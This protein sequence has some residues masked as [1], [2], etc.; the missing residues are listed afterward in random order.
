MAKSISVFISSKMQ[1]LRAERQALESLLPTLGDDTVTLRPW[2]FESDATAS[3]SS[4]R[5][6]YLQALDES[7][8]YIGLFWNEYGEWTIDEFYRAGELGITRHI[9]VKDVHPERRDPRLIEFLEKQSDVRFGITPRW[10]HDVDELRT[11]VARSVEQWLMERQVAHHSATSVIVAHSEDDIPEVPRRLIGR[12]PLIEQVDELLDDNERVLLRGFGGM[13]KTAL[14]ASIAAERAEAGKT[15]VIWIKA[16]MADTSALFEAT[17]RAFDAQQQLTNTTG[18]ERIQ[19]IRSILAEHKR[20]LVVLDDAWNGTALAEYVKAI[21]RR[22]PLLVTS[23]QRFPLDVIIE[24]GELAPEEALK[25]LRY[26]A[27]RDVENDADALLLCEMLGYHA[28]ALEIA[29]KT[30]KVYDMAPG[31]LLARIERAPHDLQ[32]PYGF[33]ELGRGGIKSLLDA[34]IDA[35]SKD[36][37]DLFMTMGGL[38]EPTA[39]PE[40]LAFTTGFS[41]PIIETRLSE[42]AERGLANERS[43]QQVRYY[44]MHDLAYSYARTM[45]VNRGLSETPVIEAARTFTLQYHD[46]LPH[47]DIEQS[48]ILEAVEAAQHAGMNETMIDMMS[49]LAV[50]G[51]YFA[52]RGHSSRSLQLMQATINVAIEQNRLEDAHYLLSRLGNTYNDF[53]G[54]QERALAVYRQA[55]GLARDLGM[56]AREAILLAV[57]AKVRFLQQAEDADDYYDQAEQCARNLDDAGAL[58]FVL[59]HRGFHEMQK[60]PP[61]YE[62]GR[63]LSDEAARLAQQLDRTDIHFFSLINRGGCELMLEQPER[64]LES[65]QAALDVAKNHRSYPWQASALQSIGE[66]YHTMGNIDAAQNAFDQALELWRQS[67][68]KEPETVLTDFMDDNGYRV[69]SA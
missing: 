27:R 41:L 13:G 47:L 22:M 29:G 32:M 56:P 23:R 31:D 46:D 61:D 54:D 18:D 2:I 44:R 11:Q 4:I 28:F 16:G 3:D 53:L 59:H 57:I 37:L 12:V 51:P 52:A 34:S 62:A 8:L 17:A 6:V 10:F 58:A 64:A 26:H 21:P 36:L 49:A 42:L 60:Q 69:K 50:R 15:P 45:F 66:D 19:L 24:V 5:Q 48:N 65:H 30:L 40:L 43:Q 20:G 68:A 39:T 67:G 9:Y 33:G 55:L 38:F 35:L 7:E 14:A 1:E 25:L 63:R